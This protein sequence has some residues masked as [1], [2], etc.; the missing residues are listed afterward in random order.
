MKNKHDYWALD[1]VNSI[2]QNVWRLNKFAIKMYS[3]TS[4]TLTENA[5]TRSIFTRILHECLGLVLICG[6]P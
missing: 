4:I 5:F 1:R 6:K 3:Q 2:K